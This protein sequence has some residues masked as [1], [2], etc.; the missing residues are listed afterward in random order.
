[1]TVL[2]VG[3][4]LRWYVRQLTGEAKWDDYVEECAT[5]CEEPMSRREFERLRDH[6]REHLSGGRCC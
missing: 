3:R 6:E 5:F 2:E 1:M 4:T